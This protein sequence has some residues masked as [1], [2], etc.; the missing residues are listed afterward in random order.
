L[1][2]GFSILKFSITG[3]TLIHRVGIRDGTAHI[4]RIAMKGDYCTREGAERLKE[5]I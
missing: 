2:Y 1:K 5:Q 3:G 4:M